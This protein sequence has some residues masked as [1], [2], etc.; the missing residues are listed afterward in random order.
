MR[1]P[2]KRRGIQ[3]EIAPDEILIDS[4]TV[5][6]FDHDQFEGRLERP[7]KHRTFVLT[8]GVLFLLC[9]LLLTRAGYMQIVKGEEYAT[10]ARE[11]Q[12]SQ[13]AVFASRGVIT[14]RNGVELAYNER[15]SQEQAFAARIYA[16]FAG[17]AHVVGY[18]KSPAKDTTGTYYR[19]AFVG[20]DGAE[21]AFDKALAGTNGTHLTETDARGR[22]VAQST[23]EPQRP[24]EEVRLS[25]DA[26]VTE[27]LYRALAHRAEE[28]GFKGGAAVIM[29]VH[30]GEILAMT[31]YPEYSLTALEQGDV[32]ALRSF[33]SDKR[34]PFLNR[35]TSGLYAP[36]SIVKPFVAAAAL[37]EGIINENKQILST[38]A[39][40]IPN[41]YDKTKP[42]VFR[43]W[44][45][46]G[47]V[48]MRRAIAVS[49]DVY[50]YAVGGGY[51]GQ[52]GLGI[53]RLDNYFKLFGFS[54]DTG[55]EGFPEQ[56][57]NIPTIEWKAKAFPN[58]PTWRLGNTYHTSIGQY[59]MQ[60]TP[61]QAVRAT[62]ALANNGMLLVPTILASSTPKGEKITLSNH[63]F[64]V[65]REGMR[66]SVTGGIAGAVKFDF[67]H[68]AAK[69]GTAEI[70]V[71]NEFIN[72][73]MVGFFP[74]EKPRY[75]FA[76]V[77]ERGPA[78]TLVGS[79]AAMGQFFL[80]MRE[81]A[82]QYVAHSD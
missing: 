68:V 69:T 78:H 44:K 80:W 45:A 62:A 71:R 29:D 25:I 53:E 54:L 43:D 12:L 40:S 3:Y 4:S 49:S 58:D 52:P 10:I 50:F 13:K 48:D 24:G 18:A 28:S 51:Q 1:W 41:P 56:S 14:D 8:G 5:S 20:M 32:T 37:Q 33:N 42:T 60:V 26:K 31:S 38:G 82:P 70:G 64:L 66:L 77:L 46:H 7:L 63:A 11:N 35:V 72:S 74:Y 67:V 65:A 36:G 9:A 79:P 81:H 34:Q 75:A 15:S 30:T 59:G 22:V 19:E 2:W 17:V 47:W 16:P 55:L 76:M 61:L 39:I 23:I 57:G 6:Q 27:G 21:R 73:W